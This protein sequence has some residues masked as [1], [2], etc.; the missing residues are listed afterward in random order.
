MAEDTAATELLVR[1]ACTRADFRRA[2]TLVYE[3]YGR[4]IYSFLLAQ[5]P[6]SSSADDV[7]S[8]FNEDF[9]RGLPSFAWRC[10]IR[11]WCYHL[12]RNAAHRHRRAPHNDRRR[13]LPLSQS[14]WAETAF[15]ASRTG[16]HPHLQTEVKNE[17][18]RLRE[19]LDPEDRDLLTLRV[20]RNLSWSDVVHI[21]LGP[22][23]LADE[24]L[25]RRKEAAL[26]Q[27][28]VELKKRLKQLAIEAG[29]IAVRDPDS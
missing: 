24:A 1:D 14:P 26:R 6:G 25:L 7:F 4:E 27:R 23:Q 10:S 18:Q 28:Y 3:A 22:E 17:F 16:T 29:L 8:Q 20:D 13:H 5:F 21:M 15:Q 11:A 9:W 12:A 2:A 19:K